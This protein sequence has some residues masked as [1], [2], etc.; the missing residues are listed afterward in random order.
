MLPQREG[1]V[2]PGRNEIFRTN[3]YEDG[4]MVTTTPGIARGQYYHG[5]NMRKNTRLCEKWGK[6][7]KEAREEMSQ[8][9]FKTTVLLDLE[10]GLRVLLSHLALL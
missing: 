6:V 2:D 9:S 1:A 5:I 7:L 3:I 8:N 10:Q 4:C